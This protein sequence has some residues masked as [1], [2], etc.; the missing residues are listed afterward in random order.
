MNKYVLKAVVM[1]KEITLKYLAVLAF[2]GLYSQSY[3]QTIYVDQQLISNC[4]GN[5]SISD[6]NCNGADGDAHTSLASA[7]TTAVAGYE[8]LIRQGVYSEQLSPQNSGTP[9]NHIRFKNFGDELV[10]ITGAALSPA[11][12]IENKD[13][14]AIEGLHVKDVRRWLNALGSDYLILKDNIFERA[15]DTGGSSKTGI[16]LQSSNYAKIQN[17][18]LNDTTQDNLGII[19]GDYNLIEGNTFTKGLHALWAFKCSNFNIIRNNYF[20]NEIQKIGEIYDCDNAGFGSAEFPKLNS[21]DDAKYNVVEG[22]IFAYTPSS[23]N[24]SPYAG[25]Q[26]AG[27]NGILRNN[28]FYECTGPALS[29]TYY[30]G[31]AEYNYGNKIYHN[32]FYDNKLGA[33]E[34]SGTSSPN[35]TKQ[36]FKNNILYKNLFIQNDMRWSW[37]VELNNQPVQI[38]TGR[39][40][41]VKFENNN[42][43]NSAVDELYIIAFGSRTSNSNAAPQSLSWWESNQPGFIQ[44]SLQANPLFENPGQYNFQLEPESPMIDAGAFLAS[45]TSAA[46]NSTIMTVD[47]AGWFMDGFGVVSGDVVQLEG[48]VQTAIVIEVDYANNA[49]TLNTTLSWT[50]GQGL[51][52]AYSGEKPDIGAFETN[53]ASMFYDGFE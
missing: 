5:Y 13:Y 53:L 12:W 17:N 3:A 42:I 52:L 21:Y 34:I 25:I 31:E 45:T 50:T 48:Q 47:D 6:R 15:L 43:F 46:T 33:L 36:R 49:L 9:G 7:A 28:T 41:Q 16:F 40:S 30:S 1:P 24:S 18:I 32:V 20:H 14:I 8:V 37:Y 11:I 22:N 35:F 19:N 27:Q 23:G 29:L 26:Y 10:E 38:L 39:D 2:L 51:S 4:T 44:T